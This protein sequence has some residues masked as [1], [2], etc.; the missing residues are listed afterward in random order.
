[1]MADEAKEYGLVDRVIESREA[2]V[3]T[4]KPAEENETPGDSEEPDEA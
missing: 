4:S 3:G 2:V 1:M